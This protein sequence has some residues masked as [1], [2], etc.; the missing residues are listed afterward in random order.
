MNATYMGR[1]PKEKEHPVTLAG[2][3]FCPT[4]GESKLFRNNI[5]SDDF[6]RIGPTL[7]R[8]AVA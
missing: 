2:K 5:R 4:I 3:P 6:S 8:L 7:S 1:V